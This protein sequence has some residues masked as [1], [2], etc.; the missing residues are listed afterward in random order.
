MGKMQGQRSAS[1]I[2][3]GSMRFILRRIPDAAENNRYEPAHRTCTRTES[4]GW[5]PDLVIWGEVT[6]GSGKLDPLISHST[7]NPAT[8]QSALS[9]WLSVQ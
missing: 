8:M 3:A 5:W 9:Y 4:V 1:G 7:P 6:H 2:C